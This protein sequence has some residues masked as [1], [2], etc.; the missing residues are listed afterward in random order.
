MDPEKVSSPTSEAKPSGWKRIFERSNATQQPVV[1]RA[2]SEALEDMKMKPEK[3]SM[4]VLNDRETEEVPGQSI[5]PGLQAFATWMRAAI[6]L[7]TCGASRLC[8]LN[9]PQQA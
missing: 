4:G 3:W 7:L 2:S 9:V 6:K 5:T 8:P 1:S